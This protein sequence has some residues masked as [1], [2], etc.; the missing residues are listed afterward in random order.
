MSPSRVAHQALLADVDRMLNGCQDCW[1][2]HF[3]L[4]M[5]R[6][7][8]IQAP[9]WRFGLTTVDRSG[10]IGLHITRPIVHTALITARRAHLVLSY[11]TTMDP[12][13]GAVLQ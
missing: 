11:G 6:L 5:E 3:L 7:G 10:I 1:T 12:R 2:Y 13:Q 9:Q 4:A 8:V